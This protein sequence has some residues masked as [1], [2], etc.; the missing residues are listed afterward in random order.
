[1]FN[2]LFP[3][4][5]S[6][7]SHFVATL[8][9]MLASRGHE[10]T[11]V[12]ARVPGTPSQEVLNGVTIE[13][14]PCLTLP[15][16]EI[17][18]QFAHLSLTF[19]PSNLRRVLALCERGRFDVLHQHGQIFDTALLSAVVSRKLKLP[20][21]LHIHTPVNH[22]SPLYHRTLEFLDR[23]VLRRLVVNPA[24]LLIAPDKTI[25]DYCKDRYPGAPLEEIP[26]GVDR[27]PVGPESGRVVR[28]RLRLGDDPVI[29]SIGHVHNLRDR[30]DLISAMPRIVKEV[31]LTRLVVIGEIYTQRPVEL[32]R[33]L[34]LQ[35]HVTFVG[36]VP[37]D[38]IGAYLAAATLEAHWLNS[39]PGLGIAAMEAMLTGVPIVSSIGA[40]DLGVGLLQPGRNVVLIERGVVENIADAI[41]HL[42][43]SPDLRATMGRA[44]RQMIEEHFS[45][46]SVTTLTERVYERY[47]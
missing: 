4:I 30:C 27:L 2:N 10:V 3:P 35:D 9:R 8:S 12:T 11:V 45:W 17:A 5:T 14:L 6:G 21:L 19:S 13:R 15:R 43:R 46:E 1:M 18:H 16:L 40:D 24:R 22:V 38:E 32:V 20:C 39:G 41:I 7:S 29:L 26:Y 42:L 31:P 44:G 37:H 33:K 23:Q 36:N 34:G 28:A 47:S 25:V